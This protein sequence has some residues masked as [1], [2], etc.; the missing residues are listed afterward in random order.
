MEKIISQAAVGSLA[1]ALPDLQEFG[2]KKILESRSLTH[3]KERKLLQLAD[4]E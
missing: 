1:G 3:L 4:Q 2:L